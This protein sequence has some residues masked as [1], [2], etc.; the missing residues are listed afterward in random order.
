MNVPPKDKPGRPA[1]YPFRKIEVGECFF[2]PGMT[3][4]EMCKRTNK[5]KPMKF[6]C[7]SV[8]KNGTPGVKVTRVI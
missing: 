8:W 2:W 3:A 5:H 7:R 1:K 4:N 6:R